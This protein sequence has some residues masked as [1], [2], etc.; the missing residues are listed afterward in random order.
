M[1]RMEPI[2]TARYSGVR[3]PSS[4]ILMILKASMGVQVA[5]RPATGAD[6][7]SNFG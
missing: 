1:Q 2:A 5:F 4:S 7:R 6:P 3:V